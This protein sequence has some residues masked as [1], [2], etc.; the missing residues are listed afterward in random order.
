MPIEGYTPPPGII[1]DAERI[2]AAAGIEVGGVEYQVNSRDGQVYYCD[3]NT[4]S[5]FVA[6]ARSVVGLDPFPR[7]VDF[8]LVRA[9]LASPVAA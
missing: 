5:N 3:I 1:E 8:L 4:L 2:T 9:G 7:L 6:D